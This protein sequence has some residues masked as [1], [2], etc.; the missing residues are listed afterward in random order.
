MK[1]RHGLL[2]GSIL[3][4]MAVLGPVLSVAPASAQPVQGLYVAGEGGA[5][6]NQDQRVRSSPNFPDG[7]DSYH[8]GVTGIGSVGWGLGNGFRVEVE[9]DYRNNGLKNFGSA[10]GHGRQQTYGVMANALFDLDIG[11]SWLFPYFGAGVGYAWQAMNAGATGPGFDQ[12]IGGTF[13]NFAYQGIFGLAFPMPWVVGLS[14]TA[15]YRF[16]T[17]L[18]PQSHGA[19]SIGTVGGYNSVKDFGI[20]TGNRDTMTDFNHSLMLGLRYEFNPAPPP[21]PPAPEPAAPAPMQS[22]TYLVFFDWD[23]AVLTDR[24]RAIVATAAQASTHTG[25]TR[26]EV[27]GYTD[28]SAAHPGPRGTRYNMALSLRR[29]QT[30][31]AEL[32]RDGVPGTAI[33]IQG[34][35]ETHPLVPTGPN[36]REPQNRRVE[37]ILH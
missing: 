18:G 12:Q 32:V 6:F 29:A 25:T 10:Q 33:D 4:A 26:I 27:D 1:L 11:K 16:W 5:S 23:K 28:N 21:P 31:Q 15:E 8:T 17:M 30:V 24:A 9:G 22:R 2:T 3:A 19:R 35:G 13:G 20:A 36:T 14:A 7:R 34:F 37:I